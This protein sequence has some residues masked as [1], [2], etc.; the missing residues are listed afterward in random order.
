MPSNYSEQWAGMLE[1][2]CKTCGGC[3]TV[4]MAR[5]G[6]MKCKCPACNGTGYRQ[7]TEPEINVYLAVNVEGL[8]REKYEARR[9]YSEDAEGNPTYIEDGRDYLHDANHA[10]MLVGTLVR[11]D[12][13]EFHL[14]FNQNGH[15]PLEVYIG[16]WGEDGFDGGVASADV[17]DPMSWVDQACEALCL[18]AAKAEK[19]KK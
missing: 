18:A 2:P 5:I 16:T 14:H 3:G 10:L 19:E 6:A 7:P 9:W 11:D 12:C 1:L 15:Q 17:L 13:E 4:D 8:K